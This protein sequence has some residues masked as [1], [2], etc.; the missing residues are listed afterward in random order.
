MIKLDIKTEMFSREIIN[1]MKSSTANSLGHAGAIVRKEAVGGFKQAGPNENSK[2]YEPPLSQ[3]GNLRRSIRF[4]VTDDQVD[5]FPG[6]RYG[7]ILEAGAGNMAPRP[8]MKPAL[9][10]SLDRIPVLWTQSLNK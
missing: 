1:K 7:H 9:D 5:I 6:R 8:F 3:T 4:K 10:R 2:P